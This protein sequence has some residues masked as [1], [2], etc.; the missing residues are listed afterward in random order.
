MSADMVDNSIEMMRGSGRV[1]DMSSRG[2]SCWYALDVS[3]LNVSIE[4]TVI[5]GVF[6]TE[7]PIQA[8]LLFDDIVVQPSVQMRHL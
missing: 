4:L 5:S 7:P 6:C 3:V 2:L 1:G 8:L